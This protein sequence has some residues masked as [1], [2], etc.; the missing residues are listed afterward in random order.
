MFKLK[1]LKWS[2][3]LCAALFSTL[4]F[5]AC[6]GDDGDDPE[7]EDTCVPEFASAV[8]TGSFMGTA[9]TIVEGTAEED[10][11]DANNYRFNLYGEAVMGDPCD[12]FNFDKPKLSII[13]SIPK[14]V[15]VYNLGV[16]AGNT[17]TFNDAT[18]VNEVNADI[19]TCGGVEILSVTATEITGR[20][21]AF[22]NSTSDLNGTFTVALCP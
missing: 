6:G 15:G 3:L 13:F 9:Y 18:V 5:T 16:A 1:Q 17:V 11:A 7:P 10:F 8:A 12:G 19:A 14:E 22:A 21:D 20:I 4:S 2:L